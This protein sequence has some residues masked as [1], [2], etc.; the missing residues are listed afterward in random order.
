MPYFYTAEDSI[1]LA[2]QCSSS[3]FSLLL[4]QNDV[5]DS[6]ML[7]HDSDTLSN[8]SASSWYFNCDRYKSN[9]I[10][11][12]DFWR[13]LNIFPF[14]VLF[15]YLWL[16]SISMS[17]ISV[18]YHPSEDSFRLIIWVTLLW[19]HLY[20]TYGQVTSECWEYRVK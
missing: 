1:I 5:L 17:I 18:K 11:Y 16:I 13:I 6:Q 19:K 14:L 3:V 15:L 2:T 20:S 8:S 9:T 7:T 12:A 10:S 4:P